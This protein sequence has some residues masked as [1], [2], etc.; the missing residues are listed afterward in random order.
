VTLN[1]AVTLSA[2][3]SQTVT[4]SYSTADGTAT[5]GADYAA[6]SGTLTFNPGVTTQNAP[7]AIL[8][9][10]LNEANE[11]ILVNLTSPVNATIADAQGIGTIIDNDPPPSLSIAD[12]SVTEGNSGIVNALFAV[13]LSTASGQTVT[14]SY[15]TANGT[16][17]STDYT[18]TSG[19]LTFPAGTT[20]QTIAVPV[21]GD[22]MNEP[23]ETFTV[24]LSGPVGATVARS[25]ATGTIVNDDPVPSIS[26]ADVSLLEGNSGTRNAPFT[27][28]LSA[29]SGQTVTVAY[30]TA[31]GTAT[32]G[33]D[34]TATS[35]TATFP[36]GST[37][38]IVNV[39]VIGDTV[40]EADETFV[41]NLS[42]PVNATIARA[43]AVGTI[44]NDEGLPS[45][46]IADTSVT[47]GNSG[48]VN[49]VFN[50]TLSASS[51]QTVTVNYATA[52]G[53]AT[54]GSDYTAKSGTLTF[55]PGTTAATITVTVNG[56]TTIEPSETFT[57]TL[58]SP[59][60]ATIARAQATGTIV[61]DDGAP[62]LVAAYGFSETS[63]TSVL[64][65]SGNNLTGVISGATRTTAGHSGSALT[66]NGTSD[67]VTVNDAA[68]LDVT[69]V[70]LEAWVRPTTLSGWRTVIMKESANALAYVLYAHD[71]APRPA[72]YIN[73]GG[74][75]LTVAGTAALPLNTWTHLAMT[76]D[77]SNMRLYVNGALVTTTAATGNIITTANPLRI[78][79]NN[80][81]G[82]YFAG[83]IDDVR[84]YN[85]ALTQAEITTDMNTP[86]P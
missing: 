37:S 70:T 7:V 30:A 27:L 9:D 86:V 45:L 42:S 26:V 39:P 85:R 32:A 72:A 52:D 3:S 5:A 11:T 15:A 48:T 43:Q 33:S 44:L 75:D 73:N 49:T 21:I 64:D 12:T 61:N 66:F 74:V 19:T 63:G 77:G 51:P 84:V 25:V 56:D 80:S 55:L 68:V 13:T 71:N 16:A 57:V 8:D 40:L 69:R 29:A 58:S 34:Y 6:A 78:G 14:V 36:P 18:T 76:Y 65:S 53:T 24:T 46:T 22:T 41:L 2:P 62:G 60:N 82:E 79:G 67:W 20:T 81:W 83:Q 28:T 10:T 23:N 54:A 17:T 59:L 4:V 47:E 50:V 1:L 38:V 31:N 35:G